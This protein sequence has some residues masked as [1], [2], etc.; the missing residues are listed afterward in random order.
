MRVTP[1]GVLFDLDDTLFDHAHATAR[2]LADLHGT[3]PGFRRWSLAQLAA[4]HGQ[5]LEEMHREVLA[6][7]LAI[8][9]AREARFRKLLAR[10]GDSVAPSVGPAGGR[11]R[12]LAAQYRER[13]ESA[14]QPVP[15]ALPLLEVLKAAGLVVA[16]VT[17]NVR[18][19]QEMKLAR[20]G[21]DRLVDVL[22][23]SEDEGVAKPDAAIFGVALA[24]AGVG[25]AEA[26]MVG[27]A[28]E[29]DIAGAL[30]A[31]VR[32][33]WFNRWGSR[34]PS[35]GVSEIAGYE[36]MADAMRVIIGIGA[37]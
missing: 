31:G 16:I 18:S 28:W 6:G 8:P 37:T 11:A 34:P 13:Y 32:P 22:V 2:A 23:T 24:R 15:G 7:R 14:W 1:R 33:V 21:L 20:C 25:A 4:E 10:A 26:V 12:E 29:T 5:V 19:E 30:A 9:E 36:P 3:E 27:D 17:N 35:E